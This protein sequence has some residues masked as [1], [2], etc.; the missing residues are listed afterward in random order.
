MKKTSKFKIAILVLIILTII[1]YQIPIQ[2][3]NF[4]E[5]YG[6]ENYA[7]KSL[8]NFYKKEPKTIVVD[9]IKWTYFATDDSQ[10]KTI[11]F[12]HGMGGAYDLWWQQV[13]FF[14]KNYNIITYT[15]PAEIDNLDDVVTGIKA[16]L[17]KENVNKFTAVGTSMGGYITQYLLKKMPE[18]LDKVVFGNTFPPNDL[19]LKQNK[20][21]SKVI[22]YLP[23]IVIGYFR[24]KSLKNKLL[25]AA[26]ND[27]LLS[28]FLRSLPFSKKSF[29]NRFY[30]V[31]DYFTINP[32]N[33]KYKRVPKLIL[34]SNNDPLIPPKL[35]QEIK[36]LYPDAKVY[37]FNNEGHFP[38]INAAD[39]YNKVIK[40]FI[41]DND[42]K[43][44]I[45]S[46]IDDYFKGRKNANITLLEKVFSKDAILMY[47]DNKEFHFITV[48][49]YLDKVKNDGKK[50]IHTKIIDLD[51]KGNMAYVKT[52]FQYKNKTYIDYLTLLKNNNKWKIVSKTFTEI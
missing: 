1:L 36:E 3:D 20:T 52:L 24:E 16:I 45:E 29:I 42:V 35:R 22:P 50:D 43:S 9:N 26:H 25:P 38:Y 21:K 30:V 4:F 2:K 17:K 12:L 37:T 7:S 32:S 27:T 11:L 31:I 19:L 8:S 47:S 13:D 18:R 34:E 28:C 14:N 46:V 10:K 6:K 15:L 33:Y 44:A 48:N 23:E 39:E 40:D 51:Q 49:D 41:T 5:L